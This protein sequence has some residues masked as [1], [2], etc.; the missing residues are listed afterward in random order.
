M[1]WV[2]FVCLFDSSVHFIFLLAR[3]F[4]RSFVRSVGC[5]F[6]RSVGR[7]IGHSLFQLNAINFISATPADVSLLMQLG[8]DGVFVG[9][10]IFKSDQ[11]RKRGKAMAESVTHYNNPDKIAELSEDLGAAMSGP[12]YTK[13]GK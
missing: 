11:P 2:G 5:S 7:S 12:T 6:G 10:G 9:S 1:V 3:S 8:V 13:S 4:A